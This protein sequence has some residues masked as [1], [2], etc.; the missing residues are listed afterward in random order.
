MTMVSLGAG[1][2]RRYDRLLEVVSKHPGWVAFSG[3][4]DSTLTLKV[5]REVNSVSPVALFA[6]SSLQSEYDRDNVKRLADQ[7][8]SDLRIV[9]FDPFVRAD[10]AENLK[11]R[12]YLCKKAIFAEF[13]GMLPFGLVLLDGTNHD[14]LNDDRPGY[15]AVVELGVRSPLAMAGMTKSEV[16]Q[17]S[18]WLGLPNWGRPSSSCL[19]TR[20]P[21]GFAITPKLLRHIE[22]CE[23]IVRRHVSGHIR[24]RL[25]AGSPD[26]LLVELAREDVE[27]TGF[28]SRLEGIT[29]DLLGLGGG[30]VNFTL[31]EEAK[32]DM[33]S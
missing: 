6:D 9:S 31:R 22:E 3:G 4:V 16:R 13:Q 14:D 25:V 17:I 20:I 21:V 12:C 8:N 1:L 26:D 7:L 23:R 10:F 27:Q 18:R 19:A 30:G 11:D 2:T 32:F 24:V 28:S 29:E 33:K 5:S 15:R